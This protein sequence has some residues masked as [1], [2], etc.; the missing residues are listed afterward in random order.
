MDIYEIEK[1]EG[2]YLA[3]ELEKLRLKRSKGRVIV[4][5]APANSSKVNRFKNPFLMEQ[6]LTDV[7]TRA[8]QYYITIDYRALS[9]IMVYDVC[10]ILYHLREEVDWKYVELE[11]VDITLCQRITPNKTAI[12]GRAEAIA[13]CVLAS[14]SITYGFHKAF[15]PD[16]DKFLFEIF[17]T[18]SKAE[19]LKKN[20]FGVE[21]RVRSLIYKL[22]L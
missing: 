2:R 3:G 7:F 11:I 1:Q 9:L 10:Q 16:S 5:C 17:D 4:N 6:G 8:E 22:A 21:A 15:H 12:A 20:M 18:I 19:E 14:H 13:F